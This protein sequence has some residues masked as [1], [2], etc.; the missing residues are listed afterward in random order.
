MRIIPVQRNNRARQATA[1]QMESRL[2]FTTFYVDTNSPAAS[3]SNAGIS[4]NAPF[5]T[6]NQALTAVANDNKTTHSDTI[7]LRAGVYREEPNVW[8]SDSGSSATS[9]T[10]ISAYVNP[11]TGQYEPVYLDAADPLTGTWTQDGT[12]NRWYLSNF[13]AMTSGVWVD[14]SGSN[15]RASLQQIGTYND[16]F[17]DERAIIGSGVSSMTPGTYCGDLTDSRLYVY[18]ADGSNP[19][20]H[21][22]EYASRGN[23]IY[24]PGAYGPG[25]G[26][27][28]ANHLDFVG[29]KLRHADVYSTIGQD[30]GC[31]VY[32]V[33]D[34]RL[35]NCDIQ[36]NEGEG[37][38]LCGNA[39][40]INCISSNNGRNGVSAQG[41]GFVID[42]GQYNSNYWRL[43]TDASQSAIKVIS[44]SASQWG[45]IENAEIAYNY[46]KG[47]WYD[48]EWQNSA[49][50][51]ITG[52]Y[53]HDNQQQ[54]IDLEA[55]ENFVVANNVITNN[56]GDGI[57][58]NAV[59]NAAILNN[60]VAGN[61]G[62]AAIE[63]DGGARM[64]GNVEVGTFNN[65]IDNN[66][67]ANNFATYDL[68]VPTIGWPQYDANNTADYNLFYRSSGSLKFTDGGAYISWGD[69]PTTLAGWQAVS[70]LD[71]H[72]LVANPL[73]IG[74]TGA[75]AYEIASN[76]PAIGVG[77]NLSSVITAD[78]A[79][80]ARPAAWGFDI[81][82]FQHVNVGP[83]TPV[84]LSGTTIGTPTSWLGHGDTIA[85]VFDG[86]LSSYYDAANNSLTNWVGL[87][88]GSASHTIAQI[89]YA[90]RPGYGFRMVGGQFQV[91]NSAT[92]SSG[93]VTLYTITAI[94]VAGQLTTINLNTS[95]YRY[96]RYIGG[97]QWVNIAEMEIDGY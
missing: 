60:T 91:S 37:V 46:G 40:L 95:G 78:Y 86:N 49:M 75:M 62:V 44:T 56:Q 59:E 73:F 61:Q 16:G 96:I 71:A 85:Q 84:K 54:A 18:L 23:A 30:P 5:K 22:L 53:I 47:I 89:K 28:Y 27:Q 21:T 81:G 39:Q 15:D 87:D 64:E 38:D 31:A 63:L 97:T 93:V 17:A 6:I 34:E 66:I 10:V 90:P 77:A 1:E 12:S 70:R 65:I 82:A 43:G 14:W 20:L 4:I 51:R 11:S 45:T 2:L 92:F 9:R 94:P 29:L 72:S 25:G 67:I 50:N 41:Y 24:Q 88:L 57:F 76:S 33:N 80:A 58:L 55:S 48:T 52:N 68:D 69:Q 3:D 26:Y 74:G 42:G 35:I 36:W 83:T 79:G 8:A 13:T 32:T 7:Y 19:N